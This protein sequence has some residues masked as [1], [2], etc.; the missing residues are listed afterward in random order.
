MV[1]CFAR[2][3]SIA[4]LLRTHFLQYTVPVAAVKRA[5]WTHRCL[6]GMACSVAGAI[7]TNRQRGCWLDELARPIW[8]KVG[9]GVGGLLGGGLDRGVLLCSH[10]LF[11]R[12]VQEGSTDGGSHKI[13][14]SLSV[15]QAF[16]PLVCLSC[17]F[18]NIS[19]Y[20]TLVYQV[21]THSSQTLQHRCQPF[22]QISHAVYY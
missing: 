12:G 22:S 9:I 4:R 5:T 19:R 3:P 14:R 8:C 17:D 16:D 15:L 21:L 6:I 1:G 13:D 10:H 18:G 11:I 2:P 7:C 20:Y